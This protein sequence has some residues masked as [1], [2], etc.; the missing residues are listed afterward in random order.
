MSLRLNI[1]KVAPEAIQAL[2]VLDEFLQCSDLANNHKNLIK[3][4]VSQING[5][6]YS[7]HKY[8]GEARRSG[9]VEER[10]YGLAAWKNS[11]LYTEDERSVLALAEEVTLIGDNHVTDEVYARAMKFFDEHY[12]SHIIMSIITINAWNRLTIVARMLPEKHGE[13]RS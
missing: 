6:S 10:I 7:I 3:I 12:F 2:N 1:G 9:E 8:S 11:N 13:I 5:C 4:R